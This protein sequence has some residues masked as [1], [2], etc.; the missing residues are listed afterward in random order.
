MLLV[1]DRA[2]LNIDREAAVAALGEFR[3]IANLALEA[4]VGDEALI[5]LGV[6]PRQVA[7]V[8]VAVRI[9]VHDVEQENEIVAVG[10]RGHVG[11]SF[12]SVSFGLCGKIRCV[13]GSSRARTSAWSAAG[14]E[15]GNGSPAGDIAP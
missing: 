1:E 8:R 7:G 4:D 15:A 9:A 2:F 10:E 12:V 11:G 5:G 14:S 13:G 6:E 3:V